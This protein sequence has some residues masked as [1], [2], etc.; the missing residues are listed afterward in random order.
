MSLRP[1]I[2]LAALAAASPAAGQSVP[3]TAMPDMPGMNHEPPPAPAAAAPPAGQ[4]MAGMDMSGHDMAGMDM[5]GMKGNLGAYAMTRDASGTAWEPDSTPMEGLHSQH[6]AWSTMVHGYVLGVFDHQGGPRGDDKTFSESMLMLMGQRPAGGGTLNLRTMLSLEPLMGADGYPL[7]LQTGETADGV[8]PLI[9]R[10]HPHD[11]FMELSATYAHPLDDR[12]WAFLY[13]G[14]PGE[15]AI[16]PPAFMHRVSG[17]DDPEAPIGHH[18]L[19]A[20]HITYG[21]L[22]TGLVR[23]NWKL[24]G[25]VFNGREPDQHRW[26][27]D[28]MRLDSASV[29]LSWN[30]APDWSAQVSYAD[31]HSPEQLEP[32]VDQHRATASVSYN[33][34]LAHGN[35]QTTLAWGQNNFQPGATSDAR[36][37]ESAVSWYRHTLFA[38]AERDRKDELFEAPSPLAGRA[39]DVSKLSV[40]YIYDVPVAPHLS[41]GL[42]ALGSLYGLPEAIQ[43]TYGSSPTSYMLFVRFKIS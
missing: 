16:G 12:T 36:L 21:V 29:R 26:N 40:G 35:W 4:D 28:R 9:D 7:L 33:R 39:F 34:P 30:P 18:W 13:A 23:G 19:D 14:Y 41:A 20:T 6:G 25:S 1:L 32:D 15:P 17:M 8:H 11:L 2:L 27:F 43:P 3:D 22:T 31:I 5:G 38:R 37:L 24:E 42:G 10:Q